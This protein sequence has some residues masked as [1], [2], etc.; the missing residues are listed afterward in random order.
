[1]PIRTICFY[2]YRSNHNRG[3]TD[4]EL[5]VLRFVRA[6]KQEPLATK[7]GQDDFGAVLVHGTEP[8]RELRQT[9]AADAFDWF[10]EMA[11]ERIKRELGTLKVALVPIPNSACT[12]DVAAARTRVLAD[13]IAKRAAAAIV[14]DALRWTAPMVPAHSGGPR[15]P[16]LL[17]P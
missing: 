11:V 10:A 4:P 12:K 2:T 16:S 13:A 9:N 7:P 3:W 14:A 5:G 8:K 17:Y 1:M 15:E 6:I